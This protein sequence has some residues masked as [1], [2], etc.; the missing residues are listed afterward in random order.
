MEMLVGTEQLWH[1]M[2]I[3]QSEGHE[4]Y[5]MH[6]NKISLSP[7]VSKRWIADDGINT[8]AYG[9]S[10]PLF[11]NTEMKEIEALFTN[12]EINTNAYGYTRPSLTN[13]EIKE[14]EALFT[15]TEIK[16]IETL[17]TNTEI[18]E[19]EA[20]LTNTEIKEIEAL[21]EEALTEMPK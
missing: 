11:T 13:A 8:N 5:G 1:G 12:T 20:L 4:I 16:E 21:T 15:N 7:F 6:V 10:R 14:I 18:K 3:L 2:N 17:F 9:Y 19:I